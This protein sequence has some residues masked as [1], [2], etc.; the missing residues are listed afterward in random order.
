LFGRL[1]NDA[2]TCDWTKIVNFSGQITQN[3]R[4][5]CQC[6]SNF[7]A[8]HEEREVPRDD[9]GADSHWLV[10]SER[11]V[12]AIHGHHFSVVLVGPAGIVPEDLDGGGNIHGQRAGVGLAVVQS[13]QA[14]KKS[15]LLIIFQFS[16][17]K[18]NI[19]Y[20]NVDSIPLDQI[21]QSVEQD[22]PV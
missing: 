13:F 22:A 6:G 18:N 3:E 7:P 20:G 1:H 17:I 11:N 10:A 4:T 21:C 8:K 5:S 14:L 19:S 12:V 2:V 9:L 16:S 15:L